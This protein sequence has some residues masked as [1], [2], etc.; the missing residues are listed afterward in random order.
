MVFIE[1]LKWIIPALLVI[2]VG[3]LEINFP[4]AMDGFDDGY[5]GRG[6]AGLVMLLFELFVWLTWSKI[7]GAIAIFLGTM[8]VVICLL[9]KNEEEVEA[10]P[11]Q[12]FLT[13]SDKNL[14]RNS[15]ASSAIRAGKNYVQRKFKKR[16][17]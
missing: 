4:H 11:T 7:G 16:Q 10:K 13:D 9:P 8:A 6:G 5:T 14:T 15:L 2:G 3:V 17:S 1:K 12:N